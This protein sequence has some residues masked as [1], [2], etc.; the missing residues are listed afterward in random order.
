MA[1]S[2][3]A[4]YIDL[5]PVR[6]G[7]VDDPSLYRFC[8]YAEAMGGF[9]PAREGI[10]GLMGYGANWDS[11]ISTYRVAVFGKGQSFDA[12]RPGRA[13]DAEK[14]SAV[15]REGGKVSR[16]E[17]LRCRVRYFTDGAVLGS[18]EFVQAYFEAHRDCF[19]QRRRAGPRTL[20]GSDWGGLSCLRGLRRNVFG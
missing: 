20:L 3:V 18:S 8:G 15:M 19:A 5:N 4:A 7:L 2:T 17:A 11:A 12:S 6:A 9:K 1:L 13:V 16:P 14:A 10:C